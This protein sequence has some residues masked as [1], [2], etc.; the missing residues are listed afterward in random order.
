MHKYARTLTSG[1]KYKEDTAVLNQNKR[2]QMR[3]SLSDTDHVFSVMPTV[4]TFHFSFLFPVQL[5]SQYILVSQST[6]SPYQQEEASH[7]SM[8]QEKN[9]VFLLMH[10]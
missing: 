5:E 7:E 2:N 9:P 1:Q 10:A 3:S 4:F 8:S 6:P